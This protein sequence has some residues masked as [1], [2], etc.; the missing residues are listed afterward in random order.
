M[1]KLLNIANQVL[2]EQ[3]VDEDFK[4]KALATALAAATALGGI[5]TNIPNKPKSNI[6]VKKTDPYFSYIDLSTL[7]GIKQYATICQAFIDRRSS[8]LL[9]ITGNMM[10]RIAADV[11]NSTG[12][13]VPPELALA[14]LAVEGGVGNDN[15]NSRPIKNR[16]PYNIGNIDTG[17]NKKFPSVSTAIRAYYELMATDYLSG[18]S[19]S[20]LLS[21][22]V[23]AAGNRYASASDYE[24]MLQSVVKSANNIAKEVTK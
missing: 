21:N 24:S 3:Q 1:I 16:N 19:P 8:N 13:Y 2:E 10:A 23:N 4:K 9:N 11:Y 7:E 18:Q 6:T 14:Q 15:E 17:K 5:N 20:S 12:K 22:F